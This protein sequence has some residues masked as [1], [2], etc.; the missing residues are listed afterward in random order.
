MAN[1][2]VQS[3]LA[4]FD[5]VLTGYCESKLIAGHSLNDQIVHLQK[6]LLTSHAV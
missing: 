2:T 3:Q 4:L 6:L 5:T 1:D